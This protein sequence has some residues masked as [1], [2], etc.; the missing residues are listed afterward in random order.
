MSVWLTPDLKPF[1]G[2]TY[3]PPEDGLHRVGF[4]TVLLRIAEQVRSSS[5][6]AGSAQPNGQRGHW[7]GLGGWLRSEV[8]SRGTQRTCQSFGLVGGGFGLI[9]GGGPRAAGALWTGAMQ[10]AER[11]R[12]KLAELTFSLCISVEGEQGC[13][14]G[15]QPEDP[16]SIATQVR[17]PCAGP[18][19]PPASQRGDGH[20]FPAALQLLRRGIRRLLRIPQVPHPR[21]VWPL[22]LSPAVGQAAPGGQSPPHSLP[23]SPCI[24]VNLNFLFTYWALHR[25]TPEGARALQMALHTL[26]M[27]AHGGIHDHIA[28]V[29][30]KP[31]G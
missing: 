3:F 31:S 6:L 2:G 4:R 14:V 23:R 18:G 7:S 24:S 8:R 29:G 10:E 30:G 15:E 9:W 26:R 12:R 5:G 28:Q 27:M 16:G 25:T 11:E 20:L 22:L 13:P 1:A 17:D 19:V 21:S